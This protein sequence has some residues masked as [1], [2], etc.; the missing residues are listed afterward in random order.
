[1]KRTLACIPLL[2]ACGCGGNDMAA[3]MMTPPP[4]EQPVCTPSLPPSATPSFSGDYGACTEVTTA[5]AHHDA[6]DIVPDGFTAIGPAVL[7]D[8]NV[9]P[10]PHGVDLVVPA[11]LGKAPSGTAQTSIVLIA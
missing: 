10:F 7:V 8:G 2:V 3:D 11:D 6:G 5:L 1:M 4:A 9:G